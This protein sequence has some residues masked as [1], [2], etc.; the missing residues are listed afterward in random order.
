M[1]VQST[2]CRSPPKERPPSLPA[3]AASGNVATSEMRVSLQE[4]LPCAMCTCDKTR[5]GGMYHGKTHKG[6]TSLLKTTQ[7]TPRSYS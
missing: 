6:V 1:P 7:K 5:M 3:G 4:V 2:V